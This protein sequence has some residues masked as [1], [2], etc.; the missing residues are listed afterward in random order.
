MKKLSIMLALL[1]T[2]TIAGVQS[3]T[4]EDIYPNDMVD[5]IGVYPLSFEE[6]DSGCRCQ[7]VVK[8]T[9]NSTLDSFRANVRVYNEEG[10]FDCDIGV[11]G[12][13]VEP[14]EIQK[15]Y[16]LAVGKQCGQ[17]KEVEWFYVM[18]CQLKG[19]SNMDC[20]YDDFVLMP[21]NKITW[22]QN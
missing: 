16:N 7:Y 15:L 17:V 3:D 9:T 11:T 21:Y 8:N 6:T 18:R 1:S 2:F 12:D 19:E 5:A 22:K 4:L 10:Y 13:R 20:S 14:G